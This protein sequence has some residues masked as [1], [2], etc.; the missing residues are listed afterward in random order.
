MTFPPTVT[1]TRHGFA[2]IEMGWLGPGILIGL[3]V[4]IWILP[5][6]KRRRRFQERRHASD[7]HRARPIAVSAPVKRAVFPKRLVMIL[8]LK[9]CVVSKTECAAEP[10]SDRSI[11]ASR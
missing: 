9:R 10:Y 5:N 11:E 2:S 3:S 8:S 7:E 6:W 4:M 1:T